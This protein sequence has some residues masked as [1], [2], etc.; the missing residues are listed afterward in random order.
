MAQETGCWVLGVEK[1]RE[2][3]GLLEEGTHLASVL[4]DPPVKEEGKGG[5]LEADCAGPS[6][7]MGVRLCPDNRCIGGILLREAF[8]EKEGSMRVGEGE[9]S[10]CCREEGLGRMCGWVSTGGK[11]GRLK[12][13]PPCGHR[14]HGGEEGDFCVE[15]EVKDDDPTKMG[16]SNPECALCARFAVKEQSLVPLD[17]YR[18]SPSPPFC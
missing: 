1:V 3:L 18:S 17:F 6:V 2:W 16:D 8:Q 14:G 13:V 9:H 5:T 11:E 7:G 15:K 12:R 4:S 10:V